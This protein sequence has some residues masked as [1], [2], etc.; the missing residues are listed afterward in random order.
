VGGLM[1]LFI[2]GVIDLSAYFTD[3]TDI[4]AALQTGVTG[5]LVPAALLIAG[6]LY[7]VKLGWSIVRRFAH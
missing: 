3:V 4:V 2:L 6:G 1:L 5:T 7:A